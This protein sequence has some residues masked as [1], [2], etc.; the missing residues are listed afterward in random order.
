[1]LIQED[2]D[3]LL[4]SDHS[5]RDFDGA[6]VTILGGTGFVGQWLIEALYEYGSNFGFSTEIRVITRN[7]T[8]A[9][10]IFSNEISKKLK[11]TEFDFTDGTVDLEKS[12][13]F[14]NGATPS[15]KGTGINNHD[16]VYASTVNAANSII[17]SARKFGNRPRVVN[18]SS[19][20]VYGHQEM[21]EAHKLEGSVTTLPKTKSGYLDAK[22]ASEMAFSDASAIDLVSSVSPRLYAFAG[23]GIALSEHFAVGNFLRDGLLGAPITV[24]GNPATTRSYM[25]PTD[26]TLWILHTLL[27]PKN[28]NLN[29]GSET[30]ITML[31]LAKLISEMTSKKG[32]EILDKDIVPSNYVP[33]TSRFREIYGVS[34]QINLSEG[35]ERWIKWLYDSKKR[36]T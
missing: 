1:L 11:L 16:A 20:I 25:Y 19:G 12:D 18:L 15:T 5:F 35:I 27:N 10:K 8:A 7:S 13:F 9:R 21:T 22:L 23:P 30:S 4:S 14:I 29:I 3:S 6:T 31:E 28:E 34:E 32:V 24:N 36:L 26:L 17:R 2:I 33:S